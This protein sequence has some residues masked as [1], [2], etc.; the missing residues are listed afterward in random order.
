VPAKHSLYFDDD[1]NHLT[2]LGPERHGV[3]SFGHAISQR[4]MDAFDTLPLDNY[5]GQGRGRAANGKQR[6]RKYDDL[7]FWWDGEMWRCEF[8]PHRVFLQSPE[9]N[10]AVGGIDR[11]LEP[12][13]ID[14][15]PEVDAIL[16]AFE[17][18]TAIDWHVKLHQI[19]VITTEDIAGIT[20]TE[21]PHR[22]GQDLQIVAVFRRHNIVGGASQFLPTGGGEV[23]FEE[24]V[25]EG[26]AVC[27]EDT[28]MWHNATDIIQKDKSEMGYRDIWIM[29][30]NRWTHRTYGDEFEETSHQQ[31]LADW[32]VIRP[33]EPPQTTVLE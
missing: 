23:F 27:N 32:D 21:G 31:G 33:D 18:D 24:V 30:T 4:T 19:R 16:K 3:K 22:D 5:C 29:A 7:R 10:M 9:F 15:E 11:I 6:Y 1:I 14:P 12:L 2:G 13:D 25:P 17:F 26:H 28:H 20:V 8:Q